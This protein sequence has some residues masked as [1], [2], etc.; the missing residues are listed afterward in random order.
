MFSSMRCFLWALPMEAATLLAYPYVH[1]VENV[2]LFVY[3]F[4]KLASLI[5]ESF[6]WSCIRSCGQLCESIWKTKQSLTAAFVCLY[7]TSEH[8]RASLHTCRLLNPK[9]R[10]GKREVGLPSAHCATS[11][12]LDFCRD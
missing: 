1:D 5:Q 7:I 6:L 10:W 9:P 11:F 12:S 8:F 2:W 3:L 4:T